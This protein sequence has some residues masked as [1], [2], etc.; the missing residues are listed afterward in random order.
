MNEQR[1]DKTRSTCGTIAGPNGAGKTA[2]ALDYLPKA[3]GL[4]LGACLDQLP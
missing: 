3:A 2:L 4:P 1:S